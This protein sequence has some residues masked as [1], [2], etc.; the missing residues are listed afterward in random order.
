[1]QRVINFFYTFVLFLSININAEVSDEF[2][3]LYVNELPC[4]NAFLEYIDDDDSLRN[5]F[6]FETDE[7]FNI[8]KD[9]FN[10]FCTGKSP[11]T[12]N[13]ISTRI[14]LGDNVFNKS[15]LYAIHSSKFAYHL[16]NTESLKIAEIIIDELVFINSIDIKDLGSSQNIANIILNVS[17]GIEMFELSQ[18]NE[19]FEKI[20]INYGANTN[21]L[22]SLIEKFIFDTVDESFSQDSLSL[23]ANTLFDI[24]IAKSN[25]LNYFASPLERF[26]ARDEIIK[27]YLSN[28]TDGNLKYFELHNLIRLKGGVTQED[29]ILIEPTMDQIRTLNTI[30]T[31]YDDYQSSQK[32]YTNESDETFDQVVTKLLFNKFNQDPEEVIASLS[33]RI[34]NNGGNTNCSISDQTYIKK[35]NSLESDLIELEFL[36]YK[37]I[38][39]DNQEILFDLIDKL[40]L[41]YIKIDNENLSEEDRFDALLEGNLISMFL[42]LHITEQQNSTIDL[43]GRSLDLFLDKWISLKETQAI[44]DKIKPISS[45]KEGITIISL[46]QSYDLVDAFILDDQ[47]IYKARLIDLKETF[48]DQV[49]FDIELTKKNLLSNDFT[50]SDKI[51]FSKFI[52]MINLLLLNSVSDFVPE[53]L[54]ILIDDYETGIDN[55][56]KKQI[57]DSLE[58][59]TFYLDNIH[60]I[61]RSTAPEFIFR[62]QPL[63]KWLVFKDLL[64]FEMVLNYVYLGSGLISYEEYYQISDKRLN[65]IISLRPDKISLE[66]FKSIFIEE[67]NDLAFIDTV[68]KYDQVQKK[69]REILES[70]IIL[71]KDAFDLSAEDRTSL[72]NNYK[73]ELLN[74]Q[75]ELFK[76]ENIGMLFSHD[77]IES[78]DL[79]SFLSEDEAMLSFLSGEFF[80]VAAIHKNGSSLVVPL[81]LS[82]TGFEQSSIAIK[83]SFSDPNQ[84]IPLDTL[85]KLRLSF[86]RD[87]DLSDINNLYI[88]TDEVFSGFPFHAL[89]N[90]DN[91]KWLI[92]EYSISYLS[93][94]KLIQHIDKRKIYKRNSFAGFGNPTLNK[95]NLENQINK[96]FT[97][98]GDFSI[99]YIDQL[100]EL[101]D[102][103]N[104]LTNI[105]K[106]FKKSN[107][108]F[109]NIATEQNVF[110]NLKNEYDFIAFAT[111]S[112]KGINKFYNDRGLVL[113]PINTNSHDNDGFL[114]SEEIKLLHFQ[115][116]PMILLTA[117]NTIDSQY[118][119]SLP[120]SGLASSFMEAGADGVLLSLWN[121][122][123]KSS[124]ELNQGIFKNSNN[125]YFTQ[126][127]RNSII[128]IKNQK[129]FSHPYYW[130]PYIYLGR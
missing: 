110:D 56:R 15:L 47:S 97:E 82:R 11:E 74:I 122:N 5:D 70:K 4:T 55:L 104:E 27:I 38:C 119:L 121:V 19:D 101:P 62:I 118:Y 8:L 87:L 40:K 91:K 113:T 112:V 6:F 80:S 92:D 76:E 100:Y 42:D 7:E 49:S 88:V 36:A 21:Q 41:Y 115:N 72:E 22:Y 68:K 60:N 129:E 125:M 84:S 14:F 34:F 33:L 117:C 99:D 10:N 24:R 103:E 50:K 127:L 90:N 51:F 85:T 89:Y 28:Y 32:G 31:S 79:Y 77:A 63:D 37:L 75:D 102:T 30:S 64:S 73:F 29:F 124:S 57:N 107:L 12:I 18:F 43:K 13:P 81:F 93:G 1:M 9:I 20:S 116:S 44:V 59:I 86:L 58:L 26:S 46:T 48:L 123:S 126:A 17:L 25:N 3:D 109:Q 61:H 105:S 65:Q 45:Y 23:I 83:E 94:E 66:K 120:Y 53:Y 96:F 130:A 114:S 67:N 52:Q 69:Y 98:R 106:F 71:S 39:L 16:R 108:F 111:H 54:G 35:V 95:N 2:I 78:K 128:D